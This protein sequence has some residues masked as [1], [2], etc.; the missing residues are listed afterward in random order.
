[1]I[2]FELD[3]VVKVECIWHGPVLRPPTMLA[4]RRGP[5]VR[6]RAQNGDWDT[7][8]DSLS[9]FDVMMTQVADVL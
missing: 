1:M 5:L 7:V 2:S 3:P 8:R 6:V 4:E 9:P